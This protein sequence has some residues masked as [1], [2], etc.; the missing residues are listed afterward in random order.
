MSVII[1]V[2]LFRLQHQHHRAKTRTNSVM[3]CAAAAGGLLLEK[4]IGRTA[5]ERGSRCACGAD[6]QRAQPT[7]SSARPQG[8][9]LQQ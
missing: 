1:T 7:Y 6:H 9:L 2:L 8:L 5:D 3:D 4:A